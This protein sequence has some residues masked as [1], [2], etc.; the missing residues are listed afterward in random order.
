MAEDIDIFEDLQYQNFG[1]SQEYF[2]YLKERSQEYD[3]YASDP[4]KVAKDLETFK[5]QVGDVVK[6]P[7]NVGVDLT[8]T[9][10]GTS[11]IPSYIYN[12]FQEEQ[13]KLPTLDFIPRLKYTNEEMDTVTNVAS[14]IAIPG[15]WLKGL[16]LLARQAPRVYESLRKAYPYSVAQM[17]D[18]IL[19]PK[20][21]IKGF[22]KDLMPQGEKAKDM[23]LNAVII[24]G[25]GTV[26]AGGTSGIQE[27]KKN[28][29][30]FFY[31]PG[32]ESNPVVPDLADYE[33]D[34]PPNVRGKREFGQQELTK[35]MAYGGETTPGPF[36]ESM[37]S[38]LEEEI[39]VQ[40]IIKEPGFESMQEFDIFDEA[41]KEGY[42]EVEVANLF[43]RVPMWAVGNV[44]KWKMLLQDL[45]KN[46]KGI[47]DAIKKK[48]GT[49]EEVAVD[50][51]DIDIFTTPT[52]TKEVGAVKNKKTIIDSPE[53]E[54]SVFYSNLEARIMD[55]NTPKE[56]DTKEQLFKFLQSKG[57]SKAEVD[58]NILERY[59]N[60]ASR[61]GTKL[62][63][64]DMLEVVRQSPMRKIENVTYGDAAY[65]GTKR[66]V[67]DNQHMESGHIPGSYRENVLYLDPKHIPFDPDSLPGS[68]HDFAERYVIGWSRL[69]DRYATLPKVEGGLADAVDLKQMKTIER[70]QK[71][72]SSQLDGL[73]ASA[74][75][76][77]FRDGRLGLEGIEEL[78]GGD[79]KTIVQRE[80]SVLNDIDKPLV[81]QIS[82][83]E[84]K[85]NADAVKLAKMKEMLEGNKVTVT[86]ADE[87]Q[88]D[89][90]QQAKRMEE[91][92]KEQLGDL[93]DAN[94]DFRSQT[95]AAGQ[96]GY[97]SQY[98]DI[99]PEVA[100]HFI[101]NKSVFRPYFSTEQDLQKF[102]D[103]FAKTNK[104]FEQLAEAGTSPSK[105][106]VNLAKEARK[107]EKELLGQIE[108]MMSKES[109]QKLFP[110]LPFKNRTEW[111]SALVKR[112]LALAA[113]RLYVDKADNAATWYAV[114]PANLIKKRYG[115][116]GGTDTPLPERSGK[117]GV[118]TEEFYGG[119]DSVD[120]KG[121]HFTSV[122][123]KVLKIAAKEN[124]SEFKIIK[125]DGVG[126]VFAIKI[127]PEMLLPHKTHRKDGGMV[128]TPELIDIFEVA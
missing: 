64:A 34:S 38:G 119:P 74:Y 57:I 8:N 100:E 118:G 59:I 55:P 45:T 1:D 105:E 41:K 48:L 56:F 19:R 17:H 65:D 22:F 87:I 44:P 40:D 113:K 101:K 11:Q 52:G 2:D 121:K 92:F 63:T 26:A 61:S 3:E 14:F 51:E 62:N 125:V 115:Q 112:D 23:L 127:T 68:S 9:V 110:N 83:F 106:L 94:K 49:K 30:E 32:S 88:S 80:A 104:V 18:T 73:Y 69:S 122:L 29:S 114:S 16:N 4:K 108:T 42:E 124:N 24:S 31:P 27:T 72:L 81:T 28:I 20:K 117:K 67:Y 102:V 77:L 89:I 78:D 47:L 98:R 13:N 53:T 6:L 35:Q 25:G 70:N 86:F 79:I 7:V 109:L 93:I 120:T 123:E 103:E 71:K 60:I 39:D 12:A 10:I 50:V 97:S 33:E 82:Q 66:A 58:D 126:D 46:E 85:F 90:L 96:R 128:Y 36:S 21:G 111:G 43:G 37:Q 107:K 75:Q 91:R 15:G 95:I 116:T 76:K 84:T 5:G 99:N 54:E